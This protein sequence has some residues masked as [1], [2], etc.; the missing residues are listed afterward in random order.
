MPELKFP[1]SLPH[2]AQFANHCPIPLMLIL[3]ILDLL[4]R[5]HAL[6]DGNARLAKNP[7]YEHT[8]SPKKR[9][10]LRSLML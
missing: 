6:A 9:I 4:L 8:T 7:R 10:S 2:E 3:I 1:S 5:H